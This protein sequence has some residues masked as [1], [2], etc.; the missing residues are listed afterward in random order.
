MEVKIGISK[1]LE[2]HQASL[3]QYLTRMAKQMEGT[4]RELSEE[5]VLQLLEEHYQRLQ[6]QVQQMRPNVQE[7]V[8]EE[9]RSFIR[10]L[11]DYFVSILE[12]A[13]RAVEWTTSECEGIQKRWSNS[14]LASSQQLNQTLLKAT[15]KVAEKLNVDE[16]EPEPSETEM[17]EA[18][19]DMQEPEAPEESPEKEEEKQENIS[20]KVSSMQS[21]GGQ[22]VESQ[23]S[24]PKE[25]SNEPP[26][27][28]KQVESFQTPDSDSKVKE[29]RNNELPIT[30]DFGEAPPEDPYEEV[31]TEVFLSEQTAPENISPVVQAVQ[32]NT[33]ETMKEVHEV[34]SQ[35]AEE[36]SVVL[37]PERLTE[38]LQEREANLLQV[39]QD[40]LDNQAKAPME[41]ALKQEKTST[42]TKIKEAYLDIK[43]VVKVN[44]VDKVIQTKNHVALTLRKGVLHVN[45]KLYQL[46]VRLDEK[47]QERISEMEI[48]NP[49]LLETYPEMQ[50]AGFTLTVGEEPYL[51]RY[52][53]EENQMLISSKDNTE[54]K[55]PYSEALTL[56]DLEE[57]VQ[58]S[59]EKSE[60]MIPEEVSKRMEI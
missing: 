21:T 25:G 52:T 44:T 2:E 31:L 8:E 41:E 13:N 54:Q 30:N 11:V 35:N 56:A 43:Q 53:E 45:Q 29:E 42:V 18:I 33:K 23:S 28:E 51:V 48:K 9:N 32:K 37:T 7:K 36:L 19:V 57:T 3:Q 38:I 40:M 12:K 47:L 50:E 58:Q 1:Q 46:S 15:E 60:D 34:I 20:P 10:S 4:K 22:A 55:I 16:Q 27:P 39:V 5:H 26:S 49:T 6:E 14:I 17:L 24:S 59:K